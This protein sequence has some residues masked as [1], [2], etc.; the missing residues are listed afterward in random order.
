[1][2]TAKYYTPND[3]S[4]DKIG[5]KPTYLI[6]IDKNNPDAED[7]QLIYAEK[8]INGRYNRRMDMNQ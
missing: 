2:T 3:I 5:I 7:V 1:M 6:E 8:L 4:I